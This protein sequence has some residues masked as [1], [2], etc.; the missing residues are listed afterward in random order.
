V[1]WNGDILA[2]AL[3]LAALL[4][5]YRGCSC[6]SLWVVEPLGVGQGTVGLD[7]HGRVVRLRGERFGRET[8]GGNYLGIQVMGG[9]LRRTLPTEGCLVGDVALPLLRRGGEL[10]SFSFTGAWDDIGEP[11]A[12][13]RANLRWLAQNGLESW[14]APDAV[15]EAGVQLHDSIV[16]ARCKVSGT[17]I[18][19]ETVVFP[20]ATLVA[21][22]DRELVATASRVAVRSPSL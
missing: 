10:A 7:D 20:G 4:E 8:S 19:R 18:V 16:G 13:L 17:G 14:C 5:R 22:S 6:E 3:D 15:V 9:D 12:L 21:P 2:P 11:G 1:I